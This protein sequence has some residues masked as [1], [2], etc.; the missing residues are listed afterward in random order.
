EAYVEPV[1]EGDSYR[2]VV[3][4]GT[5]SDD[6]K[7]GTSAGKWGGYKCLISESPISY[8]YIRKEGVAGRLSVRLMAVVV[9][10]RKGRIYL[11]PQDT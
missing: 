2:F 9:E 3:K 7:K 5:P 10:G 11:T 8:E 6:L 4:L 1:V